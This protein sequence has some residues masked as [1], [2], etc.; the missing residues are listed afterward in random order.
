MVLAYVN[1][2]PLGTRSSSL[3]KY[4]APAIKVLKKSGLNYQITSMGT[5]IEGNL[6]EILNVVRDMHEEVFKSSILRV[7]TTI[8]IDERRDKEASI[9]S[10]VLSLKDKI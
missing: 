1:I 4:I 8:K 9:Q 6:N 3:S 5:I 2:I 10:K 7:V